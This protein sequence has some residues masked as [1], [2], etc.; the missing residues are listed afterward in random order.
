MH[1]HLRLVG[2]AA[3][4]GGMDDAVAVALER[5]AGRRLRLGETAAARSGGIG[6]ER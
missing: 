5:R 6:G 3:E 1:E 4:R 2:E